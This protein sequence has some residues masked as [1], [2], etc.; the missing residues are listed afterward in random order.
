MKKFLVVL[1]ILASVALTGCTE[2]IR[3]KKFGGT[4]TV[5]LPCNKK[6]FDV[7]WKGDNLWYAIRDMKTGEQPEVINFIEDSSWGIAEGVVI[8]RENGKCK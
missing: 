7:T 2:N 5:N 3:A 4:A 1:V 8:F 6:L